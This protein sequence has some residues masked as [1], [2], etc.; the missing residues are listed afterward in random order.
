MLLDEVAST[1]WICLLDTAL[2]ARF[3]QDEEVWGDGV[4]TGSGT[5]DGRFGLRLC[6]GLHRDRWST[7]R[8]M[9][10]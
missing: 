3:G 10:L 7:W 4:V 6:S 8:D 1:R 2:L 9:H 5:I